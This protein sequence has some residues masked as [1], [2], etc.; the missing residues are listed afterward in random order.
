VKD[1][2]PGIPI[3]NI[4]DTAFE[5]P[6]LYMDQ[7]GNFHVIYHTYQYTGTD[8]ECSSTVVSAHTFSRDGFDWHTSPTPP[9]GSN[10]IVE[11]EEQPVTLASRERPKVFFGDSPGVITHMVEGVCGAPAC[12]ATPYKPYC[13]HCKYM[14]WD[15]TLV[16]TL[17]EGSK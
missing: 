6:S 2:A 14:E 12:D 7:R 17:G 3:N 16:S 1:F 10:I 5:D 9:Y 11:G 8:R 15:F 4:E 13:V